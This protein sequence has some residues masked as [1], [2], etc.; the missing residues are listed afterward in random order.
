[1]L[2]A[3]VVI[4]VIEQYM[5]LGPVPCLRVCLLCPDCTIMIVTLSHEVAVVLN[6]IDE[7]S[8]YSVFVSVIDASR[9]D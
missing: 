7:P 4:S 2:I 5:F 1:M 3:C 6:K 8:C 9:R